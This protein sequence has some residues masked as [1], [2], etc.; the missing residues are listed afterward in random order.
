MVNHARRLRDFGR[1]SVTDSIVQVPFSSDENLVIQSY[2]TF[3][4]LAEL[5]NNKLLESTYF[6]EMT[7]GVEWFKTE[8]RSIG[9]DNQ[10]CAMMALYSMLVLPREIVQSSFAAQ[11]DDIQKFLEQ[12]CMNTVTNYSRDK[13]KVSYIGHIRNAVAHARVKFRPNECVIFSDASPKG[14][15]FTTELP[16]TKLGEFITLLQTVHVEFIRQIQLRHQTQKN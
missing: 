7:F 6:E 4:L 10:G 16:L 3:S 8:L 11:Y 12:H 14:E 9:V 15:T 2:I 5:H 13:S 1:S